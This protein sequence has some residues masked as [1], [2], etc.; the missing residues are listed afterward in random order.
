MTGSTADGGGY[1]VRVERRRPSPVQTAVLLAVPLLLP[2]AGE[3]A[4]SSGF[5]EFGA[6]WSVWWDGRSASQE[7]LWGHT[8]MWWARVGKL[9]QFAAG[10]VVL[11][12]L[13]GPERLRSAGRRLSA[14]YAEARRLATA[15][16]PEI[17][18][19]LPAAVRSAM[20]QVLLVANVGLA[21]LVA[22]QWATVRQNPALLAPLAVSVVA[23]GVLLL[24]GGPAVQYGVRMPFIGLFWLLATLILAPIAAVLDNANPGHLLRWLGVGF[25]VA[26]FTLDLLGS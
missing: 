23:F 5:G 10:L 2:A 22:A 8:V 3:A 4:L 17:K 6:A 9:L 20:A 14:S 25:F 18:R 1:S 7:P 21:I 19:T 26:G 15:M 24:I 13:V 16:R 12:D 11:L